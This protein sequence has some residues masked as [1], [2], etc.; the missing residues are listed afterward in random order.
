MPDYVLLSIPNAFLKGPSQSWHSFYNHSFPLLSQWGAE[1]YRGIH[2]WLF[3]GFWSLTN[4]VF[5]TVFVNH[6]GK[7]LALWSSAHTGRWCAIPGSSFECSWDPSLTE[8]HTNRYRRCSSA[9][10]LGRTP[11]PEYSVPIPVSSGPISTF[12]LG[13]FS[14]FVWKIKTIE[15]VK[16]RS[17]VNWERRLGNFSLPIH[18]QVYF[19][20]LILVWDSEVEN[21]KQVR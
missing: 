2:G 3:S 10:Y 5:L 15:I 11:L 21:R 9:Q 14:S 17:V 16:E 7:W 19:I 13:S 1:Y 20:L 4:T 18:L 8:V 6:Q 12:P